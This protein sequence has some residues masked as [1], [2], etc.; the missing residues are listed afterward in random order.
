MNEF[1][2]SRIAGELGLKGGQVRAAA[3]LLDESKTIPFIARYRKEATGGLDEVA[4][5]AIRDSIE[6]FSALDQRRS[7]I[8]KSLETNGELTADLE[9]RVLAAETMA[10]LEDI[11]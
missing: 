3:L 1:Y 9:K 2:I 5:A 4:I 11:Y 6:K 10:V 7:T 8:L